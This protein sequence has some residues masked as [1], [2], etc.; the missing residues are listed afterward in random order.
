MVQRFPEKEAFFYFL[1]FHLIIEVTKLH[2]ILNVF[3]VRYFCVIFILFFGTTLSSQE[4]NASEKIL[5]KANQNFIQLSENPEKSFLES[6]KI[7][8]E[9]KFLKVPK[10]ELKAIDTQCMYHKSKNDFKNMMISAKSLF[11]K[12]EIYKNT[13]YQG[14]AKRY[15]FE[16]NIFSGLPEIALRELDEG[17]KIINNSNEKDSANIISVKADLLITYAN[18]YSLK[19]DYKNRL[20]YIKLA[21]KEY[22]KL[23]DGENKQL[24]IWLHHA[25]VAGAYKEMNLP[26]SAKFY[27]LLSRSKDHLYNRSD[28]KSMSLSILGDLALKDQE[29]R[30]ALSYFKETERLEGYQNYLNVELLYNNI[31]LSYQK[32]QIEDSALLYK[33]KRDSLKLSISEKQNNSLRN[34]INEKDDNPIPVYLYV[35]ILLLIGIAIF[36]IFII[37]KNQILVQ[38]E[39]ISQQYLKDVPEVPTGN[40]YSKLVELLKKNDPAF[41]LYFDELFPDFSAKLL[42]INPS[43]NPSEIEFCALLKL[44]ISTHDIARYKYITLKSV[45]N[46]K[47]V[48]RKRLNIPKGVDIYN[49]FNSF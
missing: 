24:L 36:S 31:I 48:I 25:N 39:R 42:K 13:A 4:G 21:G 32:L 11:I 2:N 8:A 30:K 5:Q 22:E 9:A 15:L 46:R 34:I 17:M 26:D 33:V 47:Y 38:Q 45:Q 44:K 37:R 49:W 28:V 14:T 6:Q 23:P 19:K 29:Y 20:K 40:D 12:A 18:Y 1:K 35:L 10:A 43:L 16:A 7:E 27:A 3:M 41:L